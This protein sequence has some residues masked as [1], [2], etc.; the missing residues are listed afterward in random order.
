[1]FET[2]TVESIL[3]I[4]QNKTKV[5]SIAESFLPEHIS[6]RIDA[7]VAI[8]QADLTQKQYDVLV[9]HYGLGLTTR[10]VAAILDISQA[11]VIGRISSMKKR[12]QKV[13]DIWN[14]K[15]NIEYC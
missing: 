3:E 9:L 1:M 14:A 15:E 10:E 8:Y 13:I 7:A 6:L 5:R 11:T 12:L 2:Y 4:Y